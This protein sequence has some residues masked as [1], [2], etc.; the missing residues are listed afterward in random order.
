MDSVKMIAMIPISTER[1]ISF[2]IQMARSSSLEM[3]E[4]GMG[5]AKYNVMNVAN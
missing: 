4:N 5:E 3:T 1:I 2:I